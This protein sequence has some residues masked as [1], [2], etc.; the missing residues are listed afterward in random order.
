MTLPAA[1]DAATSFLSRRE[2]ARLRAADAIQ[3]A[4]LRQAAQINKHRRPANMTGT[5]QEA[6]TAGAMT[7]AAAASLPL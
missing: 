1:T 5:D 6:A 4:Q 3:E 2:T 7:D